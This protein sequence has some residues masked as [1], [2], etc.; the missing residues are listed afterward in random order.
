MISVLYMT[1][2]KQAPFYY[3]PTKVCFGAEQPSRSARQPRVRLDVFI[4]FFLIFHCLPRFS[5]I[6]SLSSTGARQ[7]QPNCA[8]SSP[9]NLPHFFFLRTLGN[10]DQHSVAATRHQSPSIQFLV[11]FSSFLLTFSYIFPVHPAQ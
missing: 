10:D 6:A 11:S 5:P 2:Y 8:A 1:L 7:L 9:H 3:S 4:F